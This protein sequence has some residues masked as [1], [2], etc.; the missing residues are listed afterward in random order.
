M[1]VPV[2]TPGDG[3]SHADIGKQNTVVLDPVQGIMHFTEGQA[4]QLELELNLQD[5]M[6]E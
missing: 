4:I 1:A 6:K 3:G 5:K 2:G